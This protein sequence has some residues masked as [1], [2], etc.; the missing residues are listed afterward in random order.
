MESLRYR[1]I[2]AAQLAIVPWKNGGGLTTEIASGPARADDQEW[3]WRISVA[4]VGETGA[5]SVFPGIDRTIAVVDGSGMDLEF[6]DGR[7]VPLELNQPVNFAGDGAVT[8]ILRGGTIRDFNIMVDRR[9][10]CATLSIMMG[11]DEVSLNTSVGSVVVVHT[12]DGTCT[13][14]TGAGAPETLS[15][16]DTAIYEG[17]AIVC[18]SIPARARAAIVV[19]EDVSGQ[20]PL[21]S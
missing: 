6:K 7:I 8:G 15:A 20:A 17:A 3:S 4:D 1:I 11:F 18:V 16:Q 21:G 10:Y 12:L 2:T 14:Q 5:F 13:A 9:Y 19:L